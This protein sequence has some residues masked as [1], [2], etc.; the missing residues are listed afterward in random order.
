MNV[1]MMLGLTSEKCQ[2]EPD[3][4]AAAVQVSNIVQV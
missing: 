1:S 3:F 4:Q 2:N